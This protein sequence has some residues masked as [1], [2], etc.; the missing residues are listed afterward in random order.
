MNKKLEDY[1]LYPKKNNKIP[2]PKEE[3]EQ[4]IVK[5]YLD[6]LLEQGKIVAY[7]SNPNE[8]ILSFLDRKKFMMAQSKLKSMGA[9]KGVPD[10]YIY[11]DNKILAIEMKRSDKNKSKISEEQ[12]QWIILLNKLPYID[13]YICYGA[14]NAVGL[15]N[16]YINF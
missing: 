13:A 10:L 12:K 1:I 6:F 4:K 3:D 5:K 9:K 2:L 11:L 14:E 15:I 7:H 16:K 8:N